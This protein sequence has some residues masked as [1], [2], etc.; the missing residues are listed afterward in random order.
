M[1]INMLRSK[2]SIINPKWL[3]FAKVLDDQGR[4][5]GIVAK[6]DEDGDTIHLWVAGENVTRSATNLD[7]RGCLDKRTPT[8][9]PKYIN[10]DGTIPEEQLSLAKVFDDQDQQWYRVDGL[11]EDG[12]TLMYRSRQGIIKEGNVS[13]LYSNQLLRWDR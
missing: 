12:V 6:V 13:E 1:E 5:V 7:H 8:Q 10:D 4:L 9:H 2:K 11:T 3:E